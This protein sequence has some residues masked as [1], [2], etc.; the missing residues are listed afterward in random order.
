MVVSGRVRA[1]IDSRFPLERIAEAVTRAA[2]GG[3]DG[4]V[5]L[6]PDHG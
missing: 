2:E 1:E 3:R 5:L 6:V 4:K